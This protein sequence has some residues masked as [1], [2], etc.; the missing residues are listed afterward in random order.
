MRAP[1]SLPSIGSSELTPARLWAIAVLFFGVGDAVTTG[2]GLGLDGVVEINPVAATFFQRSV[3]ATMIALKSVAF[4]GGYALWRITP[5]PASLGVPLGLALL[6]VCVTLWN[7][8]VLLS[9][10]L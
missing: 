5:S 3:F 6:G 10:V 1:E 9:T 4:A 7:C 8:L 2:V